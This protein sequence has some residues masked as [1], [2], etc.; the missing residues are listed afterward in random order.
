VQFELRELK[1][2]QYRLQAEFLLDSE[3]YQHLRAMHSDCW[4]RLRS[5]RAAMRMISEACHGQMVSPFDTEWNRS[6]PL[7]PRVG[8]GVTAGFLECWAEAL[9]E[10]E[11]SAD[12]DLPLFG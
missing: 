11:H 6:E 12:I 3:E 1:R 4:L 8:Y 10:L 9:A 7:D 5:V 2:I